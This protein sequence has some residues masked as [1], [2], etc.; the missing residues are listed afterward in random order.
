MANTTNYNWETPD[1]TDLVKDGALAIRTLGSSIDTTT[2]AL[3]PETTT[4]DIAY[5]SATANTNTRLGIGTAG[6]ILTVNSGATA[7]EWAT[8]AGGAGLVHIKEQTWSAVSS[9]NINDIFS[10]TYTHYKIIM[11]YSS[12]AGDSELLMR[13]RVSGADDTSA[14]YQDQ[15]LIV[16][17]ANTPAANRSAGATSNRFAIQNTSENVIQATIF[18]P[19]LTART[20]YSSEGSYVNGE[21]TG[22]TRLVIYG[23]TFRNSTS[24]TGMTLIPGSGT[25]TGKIN[26]W[27]FKA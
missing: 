15:R 19:F 27:G 7:P 17:A 12:S 16:D 26:V 22:E 18:N 13:Y 9:V 5:R 14:N 24:F 6:Q 4:G 3:N 10:S 23:G 2:K 20:Y 11:T 1:D 25:T 8:P 21:G